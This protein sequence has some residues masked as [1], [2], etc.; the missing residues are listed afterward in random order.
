L[1]KENYYY[2]KIIG[3]NVVLVSNLKP[4][5]MRGILSE[6][7]ILAASHNEAVSI[8]SVN[9]NT[10]AGSTVSWYFGDL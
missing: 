5:K 1:R 2:L 9:S 6:G 3:Q 8:V 10:P 7:M 4:R